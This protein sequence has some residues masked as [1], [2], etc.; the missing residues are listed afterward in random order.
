VESFTF[1][2]LPVSATYALRAEGL[3]ESGEVL[4][5]ACVDGMEVRPD[6]TTTIVAPLTDLPLLFEG[7]YE[8]G[9]AMRA[10]LA[11]ERAAT[12]VSAAA[13]SASVDVG[14]DGSLLLDALAEELAALGATAASDSLA[15]ERAAGLDALM[16][17]R[18]VAASA[19]ASISAAALD[20]ELLAALAEVG[21][22]ATLRWSARAAQVEVVGASVRG[23]RSPSLSIPAAVLGASREPTILL[24]YEEGEQVFLDQLSLSATLGALSLAAL[25]AR[26]VELE[27]LAPGE[28]GGG[29][30]IV[31]SQIGC[32]ELLALVEERS[33]L[34]SACD[35]ACVE[36]ACGRAVSQ[37]W[38]AAETSLLELDGERSQVDLGGEL[39]GYDEVGDLR[40]DR[41]DGSG[42]SGTW[43]GFLSTD[44]DPLD[45][46]LSATRREG[47]GL[48][49]P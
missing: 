28:S 41:F 36:S 1:A 9:I 44:M 19:G 40:I 17:S 43:S 4:A 7:E 42:L 37:L 10:P 20:R 5:T 2:S 27:L 29:R 24:R 32:G 13:L 48:P 26:A 11:A 6:E 18:L 39:S 15:S 12:H 3:S 38:V 8:L 33:E 45:A 46:D 31:R 35:E 34:S 14:G 21:L 30:A 22:E 23:E 49:A 16:D 25:D 47:A